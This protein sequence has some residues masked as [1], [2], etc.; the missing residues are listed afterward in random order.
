MALL[1][2]VLLLP[3]AMAAEATE[4]RPLPPIESITLAAP[5]EMTVRQGGSEALRLTAEPAVLSMVETVVEAAAGGPTLVVRIRPGQRLPNGATVRVDAEVARLGSVRLLGSGDLSIERLNTPALKLELRGSG[6]IRLRGLS[7]EQLDI[8]VF[9][10]G[11]VRADGRARQLKVSIAGSGDATLGDLAADSVE[12]SIAGSGDA[13]VRAS[14]SAVVSVAGSG[15]VVVLGNP[16][17]V[18]QSVAGSG[19]VTVRR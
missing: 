15:D 12:L 13:T 3:P 17:S 14:Q 18:T 1:A 10:S 4:S 6:D 11:D 8:A 9:G 2:A 16:P 5:V 7:T 19:E